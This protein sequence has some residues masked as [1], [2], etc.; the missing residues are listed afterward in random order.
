MTYG[1]GHELEAMSCYY[2]KTKFAELGLKVPT[3]VSEMTDVL[4]K[5]KD[6]GYLP[7][8]SNYMT[9]EWSSNMNTVGTFMYGFMSKEEIEACMNND[10]P[11]NLS[12]VKNAIT[13]MEDWLA[14]GFFP[15]NPEVGGDNSE[16]FYQGQ[17]LVYITGNWM[18]GGFERVIGNN[19]EVGLFPFP[20]G[21]PGQRGCQVN[22]CGSGYMVSNISK[23]KEAALK[24]IDFV[25]ATP[26]SAKIWYEAGKVIPPYT[27]NIPG[28]QVSPLTQLVSASLGDTSINNMA[29]INMWLPPAAFEFFSHAG[30]RIVLKRINHDSLITELQRAYDSDQANKATRGTYQ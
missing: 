12:S 17:A 26:E 22:F 4:Q 24:Y 13:C 16:N 23:N 27:G 20:A 11:W 1:V 25:M 9:E 15:R 14:K 28:L 19:F 10:G 18:V 2:N 5:I 3:T 21:T 6:A 30:Q 7:L 29:G 8:G